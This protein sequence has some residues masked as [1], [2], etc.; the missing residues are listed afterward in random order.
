MLNDLIVLSLSLLV[1]VLTMPVAQILGRRMQAWDTPDELSNHTHVFNIVRTGGIAIA[2]GIY[3][4][5]LAL[6]ALM[7]EAFMNRGLTA[8]LI[9][10]GV[11]FLTGLLDDLH[12]IKPWV[13]AVLLAAAALTGAAIFPHMEI[14][15]WVRLDFILAVLWLMGMSNA[16]NLMDG[17]DGLAA[18]MAVAA[19]LGL[20][21]VSLLL[22]S[23][24]GQGFK[25]VVVGSC[26]GFLVFNRPPARIFM[27]DCGSL[28]IGLHLG[29]A[30]LSQLRHGPRAIIPVLLVMSPFLL[31]TGLAV[32]RRLLRGDDIF[33]GD[34]SHSY[35]ILHRHWPGAWQVDLAMWAMGLGFSLLGL[36]AC[37][38]TAPWQAAILAGS[39]V[40]FILGMVRRGMFAPEDS[41]VREEARLWTREDVIE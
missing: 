10:G 39:W 22:G 13:K 37:T 28:M 4:G 19:S 30:A 11:A 33:T 14:T 23:S 40:L 21:A 17:M 20:V 34:R 32:L 1:T 12:E 24:Y 38:V 25:L 31:D 36:A 9:G 6:M 16:F 2:L 41:Q 15:G 29:G 35:D 3:A 18:G 26:L 7:P 27:G 5:S 8:A